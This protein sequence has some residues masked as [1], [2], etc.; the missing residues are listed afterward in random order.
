MSILYEQVQKFRDY[1]HTSHT[2]WIKKKV[3]Y[4][5]HLNGQNQNKPEAE[6]NLKENLRIIDRTHLKPMMQ[7]KLMLMIALTITITM[8]IILPKVRIKAADLSVV[9]A[10]ID[11]L[12]A[13]H[14][15]AE[16]KDLNTINAN[17]KTIDFREAHIN[18][19]VLNKAPTANP[20]FR[21]IKQITTEG[22]AG[23]RSS[24]I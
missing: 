18:R 2:R 4:P 5:H 16:A 9:K 6:V 19:T 12:E 13:S 8:I 11:N 22:E 3:K 1:I 24:A 23:L 7:M 17:F 10:V 15:E 14:K 21:E 20:I